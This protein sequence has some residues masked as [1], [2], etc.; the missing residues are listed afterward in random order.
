MP[1][2]LTLRILAICFV[3]AA[4]FVAPRARADSFT[5][6]YTST[7]HGPACDFSS[8]FCV[9][10]SFTTGPMAAVTSATTISGPD[11]ASSGVLGAF[12]GCFLAEVTLDAGGTGGQSFLIF[13]YSTPPDLFCG[14]GVNAD[15]FSLAD[16][17]TPGT[18]TAVSGTQT[19][20]LIVTPVQTPEPSSLAYLLLGAPVLLLRRKQ[21]VDFHGPVKH[22]GAQ[23]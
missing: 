13:A 2:L 17:S 8:D 20:T 18:Y 3:F 19:D 21:T 1:R 4:L 10:F 6:S 5:Y 15:N 12:S 11:L 9:D 14:G 7:D 23:I 16:Y 22:L